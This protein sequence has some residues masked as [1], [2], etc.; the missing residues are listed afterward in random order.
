MAANFEIPTKIPR[1]AWSASMKVEEKHLSI[2]LADAI[3][4]ISA[5][6]GRG[7][8]RKDIASAV[9]QC[10]VS[11]VPGSQAIVMEISADCESA[12]ILAAANA[13]FVVVGQNMPLPNGSIAILALQEPHRVHIDSSNA[14]NQLF[15][16][17]RDFPGEPAAVVACKAVPRTES[18]SVVVTLV[19]DAESARQARG[20][21]MT[22]SELLIAPC[23]GHYATLLHTRSLAAIAQAKNE[24][25]KTVDALPEVVCLVDQ[26]GNVVRSNRTIER[27]GLGQVRDVRGV[28]VHD[29]LHKNC[30][31]TVC[32]LRN[33]VS[34]TIAAQTSNG[35]LESAITDAELGKTLIVHTRLMPNYPG[36]DGQPFQPSAVVVVSDVSALKKVQQDLADL[37]KDLEQRVK[38]RTAELVAVVDELN[39]EVSRRR[40]AEVELQGSKDEMANLTQLLINAQEDERHRLSRELHDS[41]GQSLG[42][43][44]YSLERVLALHEGAD[45]WDHETEITTIIGRVGLLI[46]EARSMAMGLRPPMLDDIGA[47]SAVGWLCQTFEETYTDI[48][49]QVELEVSDHD[50]PIQ[51]STPIYRIVQE[52]VNNVVKHAA[53]KK[54]LVLLSL[55]DGVLKLEILDDGVGFDSQAVDTGKFEKLG[56]IGRLGMRERT[57][58]SGGSLIVESR[59]G[60][61]TK[62]YAEWPLRE[63]QIQAEQSK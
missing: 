17:R 51:L 45:I 30:V 1:K 39:E 20:V 28:H 18:Q 4:N 13:P 29:L 52:A 55:D 23:A 24:W 47:V 49:F 16:S 46:R 15:S 62:V 48:D 61:G 34:L 58:N 25:E 50:I 53:A 63:V 7:A 6:I 11:T 8:A 43:I 5:M 12:N 35:Y 60:E 41:L 36:A 26:K 37:N 19:T 44:K 33:A 59:P 31:L 38:D 57:I 42:A 54:A 56:K 10:A 32:S 14:T 40:S 27:W 2:Q 21:M 9:A 3:R 22:L